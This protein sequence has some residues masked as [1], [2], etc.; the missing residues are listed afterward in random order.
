MHWCNLY[1][2][3]NVVRDDCKLWLEFKVAPFAIYRPII[4]VLE[5]WVLVGPKLSNSSPKIMWARVS[6]YEAIMAVPL[7]RWSVLQF[8]RVIWFLLHH[9]VWHGI[10]LLSVLFWL[11]L[12]LRRIKGEEMGN[13]KSTPLS[14]NSSIMAALFSI[15]Q[16][17]SNPVN[18]F[19]FCVVFMVLMK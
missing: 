2:L 16:N 4:E 18:K 1:K 15:E 14:T 11:S 8:S 17:Y 9:V 5:H 19:K 13:L 3:S 6:W 12:H 7:H 10:G